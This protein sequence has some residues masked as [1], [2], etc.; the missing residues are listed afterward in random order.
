MSEIEQVKGVLIGT[1]VPYNRKT[2]EFGK[3]HK[4]WMETDEETIP[5]FG[6]SLP[7]EIARMLAR[8]LKDDMEK[9]NTLGAESNI[10]LKF[11]IL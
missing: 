2:N 5:E 9:K 7:E 10:K 4:L 1:V 6:F 11:T 8:K 3:A